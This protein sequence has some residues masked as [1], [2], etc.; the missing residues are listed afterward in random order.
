MSAV[1]R[2]FDIDLDEADTAAP[3]PAKLRVAWNRWRIWIVSGIAA[4]AVLAGTGFIL[5]P[6]SSESTDDA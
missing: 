4:I 6:A 5:A 1:I 2:P 3:A